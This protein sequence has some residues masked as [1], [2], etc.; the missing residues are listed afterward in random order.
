MRSWH[1]RIDGN[2]PWMKR[3]ADS[4]TLKPKSFGHITKLQRDQIARAMA[5]L[6]TLTDDQRTYI[7]HLDRRLNS[8]GLS[9]NEANRLN[10]IISILR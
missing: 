8:Y 4:K 5:Q 2:V 9:T 7:E 3:L 10:D 6:D 1:G